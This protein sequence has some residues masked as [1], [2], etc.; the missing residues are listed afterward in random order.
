MIIIVLA[1]III[2]F[3][4]VNGGGKDENIKS[5]D[6]YSSDSVFPYKK[7]KYLLTIAEK[8]FYDALSIAINNT[9]YY[10]CPKVRLADIIYV[11]ETDKRQ[12]YFNKIKSKHIDFLLCDKNSM[13]PILAIEL[14]DNSHLRDDRI[15]RDVFL[16]KALKSAGLKFVRFRVQQSYDIN[17]I[18][19]KLIEQ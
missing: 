9:N 10:I 12:S 7:K 18:K 1:M 11:S 13:S 5:K 19:E 8:N 14:D 17:A 6:V 16:D 2:F 3:M 15:N 4:F